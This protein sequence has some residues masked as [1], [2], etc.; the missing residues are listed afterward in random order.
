MSTRTAALICLV[1]M[2]TPA[3]AGD[4]ATYKC[5]STKILLSMPEKGD[6]GFY[7]YQLRE[8]QFTNQKKLPD[9]LFRFK[10]HGR[11]QQPV[12]EAPNRAS[13]T[14][15]YYRGKQCIEIDEP[16]AGPT[17]TEP[18]CEKFCILPPK[19]FDHPYAGK[20]KVVTV[21]Q[22]EEMRAFCG[23][24]FRPWTLGCAR[25]DETNNS[26]HI[27]IANDNIIREQK[28]TPEL[29]MRHEI[30]HC[31]GWPGNHPGQRSWNAR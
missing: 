30:G 5:G 3:S 21:L 27:V 13:G 25:R 2:A 22:R 19:Q 17:L 10:R 26:C 16:F 15:L 11:L 29:I 14:Y 7:S 4:Y 12:G 24:A 1:L 31:N 23:E 8:Y 6:G 20:L 28:W 18:L 9:R